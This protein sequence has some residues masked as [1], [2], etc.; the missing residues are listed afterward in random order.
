MYEIILYEDNMNGKHNIMLNLNIIF[1]SLMLNVH[2]IEYRQN[3]TQHSSEHIR[4][5]I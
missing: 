4:I 3:H 1:Y 2:Y 5:H